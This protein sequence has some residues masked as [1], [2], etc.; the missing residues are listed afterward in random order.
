MT[1]ANTNSRTSVRAGKAETSEELLRKARKAYEAKDYETAAKYIRTA[2]GQ[3]DAV[4]QFQLGA[5]YQSG[6]GGKR[7]IAEA[8]TW[9]R[10]AAEQGNT[11]AINALR[12][13]GA[14]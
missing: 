2:A 12:R 7:G 11:E 14:E 8:V 10:K 4:A 13:L 5:C 9:Y 3:D 6:I 1:K